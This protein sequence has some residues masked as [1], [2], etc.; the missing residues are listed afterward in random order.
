[1]DPGLVLQENV[2][3]HFFG[4]NLAFRCALHFAR[5]N[6]KKNTVLLSDSS[7]T[8]VTY[9]KI[10]VT[11]CTIADYWEGGQSEAYSVDPHL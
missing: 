1:V 7:Y 9:N 2:K 4:L 6:D 11:T 10:N 3:K 8:S 5:R